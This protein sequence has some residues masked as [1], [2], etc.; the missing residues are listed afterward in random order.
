MRR[1]CPPYAATI[2]TSE[3]GNPD[4]NA[5]TC[6]WSMV[7]SSPPG[8]KNPPKKDFTREDPRVQRI[9]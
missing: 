5:G 8:F 7:L 1:P 2:Y 4:F 3:R 9:T 6:W